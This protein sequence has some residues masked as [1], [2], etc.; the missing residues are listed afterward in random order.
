VR[1]VATVGGLAAPVDRS[2]SAADAIGKIG[3]DVE[4]LQELRFA[5]RAAGVE[6]G[7]LDMALQRFTRRAAEAAQGTGEAKDA[8]AQMGIVLHDQSD[9]PERA[10]LGDVAEAFASRIRAERVRLAFKLFDSEGVALV[11]LLSD[12]G[13]NARAGA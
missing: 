9:P 4:A 3:V 8:L 2:I 12:G 13:R 5:A 6:Q 10:L 7:T 11:N 1:G